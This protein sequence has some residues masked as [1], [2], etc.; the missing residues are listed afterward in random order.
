L[1]GI[2]FSCDALRNSLSKIPQE[3]VVEGVEKIGSRV[4]E[5][6][7]RTR[8][9]AR[10]LSPVALESNGLTSALQELTDGVK[11]LFGVDYTFKTKGRVVVTDGMV[12]THL[13][14]IAQEAINNALKHGAASRLL[15]SLKK[16]GD[17][18][19]LTISDNGA[20]FLIDSPQSRGMGLRTI[21][22]RAGMI[23]AALE[24]RSKPGH[25]TR[26]ICTFSPNE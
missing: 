2:R 18:V 20:G 22:Y 6:I 9:L 24:V 23:G 14:R 26:I 19:S 4:S 8:M 3:E 25:G 17:K 13:Y 12:A 10:G 11:E 21:A 5:A 15:V 1:A 7:D 16:I